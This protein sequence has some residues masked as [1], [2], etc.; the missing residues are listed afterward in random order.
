MDVESGHLTSQVQLHVDRCT[1]VGPAVPIKLTTSTDATATLNPGG[2][3]DI[4]GDISVRPLD[5]KDSR[6]QEYEVF[7]NSTED[8]TLT[9]EIGLALLRKS[10]ILV[11]GASKSSLD[12]VMY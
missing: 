3:N 9:A 6:T 7:V 5:C 4:S 12:S 10:C 8:Y 1:R 2:R 11:T